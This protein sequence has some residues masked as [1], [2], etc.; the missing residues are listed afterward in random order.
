VNHAVFDRDAGGDEADGR[1]FEG[2]L[3]DRFTGE[4]VLV[5][6]L[7][8]LAAAD[9]VAVAA[10][11]LTAGEEEAGDGGGVLR[12][13]GGDEAGGGLAEGLDAWRWGSTKKPAAGGAA[14]W[15]GLASRLAEGKRQQAA[16]SP[17]FRVWSAW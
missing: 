2:D 4:E 13:E 9:F 14:G 3:R 12:I 17:R 10:D 6:S 15:M 1:G 5:E 16:R 8:V 11:D 7:D